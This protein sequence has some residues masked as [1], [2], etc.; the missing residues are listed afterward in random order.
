[1]LW[2]IR[3][4][5]YVVEQDGELYGPFG[6]QVAAHKYALVYLSSPYTLRALNVPVNDAIWSTYR[7]G[8]EDTKTPSREYVEAAKAVQ[9]WI[10]NFRSSCG[11]KG[12]QTPPSEKP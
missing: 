7:R 4:E 11:A 6:G 8:Q 3:E 1:M 10:R 12:L 5:Q 9:E 2:K